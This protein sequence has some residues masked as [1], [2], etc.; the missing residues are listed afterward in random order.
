VADVV[1]SP[2]SGKWTQAVLK[3]VK[4]TREGRLTWT[5]VVGKPTP[6]I[7]SAVRTDAVFQTD[8][9]DQRLWL[10]RLTPTLNL[11]GSG[12]TYT[13]EIVD[14]Q[15]NQVWTFPTIAPLA[16]LYQAVRYNQAGVSTFID[17]LLAEP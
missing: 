10:S 15:G 16:D 2:E 13:L 7:V 3:L 4:L 1:S 11:F 5:R 9:A 6:S 8:Y 12:H 14:T 17:R